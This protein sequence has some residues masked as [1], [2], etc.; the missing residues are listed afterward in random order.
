MRE[1]LV[2]LTF[3]SRPNSCPWQMSALE[4]K[5]EG[6]SFTDENIGGEPL[7]NNGM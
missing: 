1:S 5:K 3:S 7:L 6:H 4:W 2:T